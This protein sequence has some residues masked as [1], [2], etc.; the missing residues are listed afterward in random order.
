MPDSWPHTLRDALLP[1]T[2]SRGTGPNPYLNDIGRPAFGTNG[3]VHLVMPFSI[4][5]PRPPI[6][7]TGPSLYLNEDKAPGV[8]DKWPRTLRDALLPWPPI[9]ETCPYSNEYKAPGVW[10][11]WPYTS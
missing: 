8:W 9:G 11:K 5:P 10:D 6:G 7:E 1:R 2:P 4:P 3:P